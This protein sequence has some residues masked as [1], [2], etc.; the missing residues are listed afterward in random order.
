MAKEFDVWEFWGKVK[1]AADAGDTATLRTLKNDFN[2]I[3]NGRELS[4]EELAV[5][6]YLEPRTK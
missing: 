1:A 6:L 5:K 3:T 2:S 4:M